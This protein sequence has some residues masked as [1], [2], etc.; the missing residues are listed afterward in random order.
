[1]V[2]F[3]IMFDVNKEAWVLEINAAPSLSVSAKDPVSEKKTV[4]ELDLHVKQAVVSE[5]IHIA[6]Q[7]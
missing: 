4:S 5:A 1:M 3:D 7:P 6:A 2:G